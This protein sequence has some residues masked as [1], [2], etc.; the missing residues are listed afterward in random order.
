MKIY[1][2]LKARQAIYARN[3][4]PPI[5]RSARLVMHRIRHLPSKREPRT[6]LGLRAMPR[7]NRPGA[8]RQ[9]MPSAAR[10][11]RSRAAR[12]G[13]QAPCPTSRRWLGRAAPPRPYVGRDRVLPARSSRVGP[14]QFGSSSVPY[15]LHLRYTRV[16]HPR[17]PR[18]L[19]GPSGCLLDVASLGQ[20][21]WFPGDRF[22]GR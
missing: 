7:R 15:P 9:N 22:A 3:N 1:R 20:R 13:R 18:P 4:M 5:P 2:A 11:S 17:P 16:T 12:W 10:R 19:P 14:L 6:F 8:R 21:S